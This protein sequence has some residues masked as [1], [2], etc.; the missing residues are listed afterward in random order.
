MTIIYIYINGIH[1]YLGLASTITVRDKPL[2]ALLLTT[3][4]SS[5]VLGSGQGSMEPVPVSVAKRGHRWV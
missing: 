4:N 1:V 3:V 2:T 5:R